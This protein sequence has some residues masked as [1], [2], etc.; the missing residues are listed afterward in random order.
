MLMLSCYLFCQLYS[1]IFL[2]NFFPRL[3]LILM[4]FTKNFHFLF[5]SKYKIFHFYH[6]VAPLACSLATPTKASKS[7]PQWRHRHCHRGAT[8]FNLYIFFNFIKI[9]LNI[10]IFTKH[11]SNVLPNQFSTFIKCGPTKSNLNFYL[12]QNPKFY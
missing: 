9:F 8:L 6:V 11:S 5:T 7:P 12:L 1:F 10:L 3:I 2:I 4:S